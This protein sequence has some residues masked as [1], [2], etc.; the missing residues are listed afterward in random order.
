MLRAPIRVFASIAA[1]LVIADSAVAVT[2]AVPAVV[3]VVV[4]A[5]V[6]ASLA[7]L[8]TNVTQAGGWIQLVMPTARLPASTS[9]G[10]PAGRTG[11]VAASAGN[12]PASADGTLSGAFATSLSAP[13]PSGNGF[14]VTVA[15]N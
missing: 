6:M 13:T 11:R 2:A 14:R 10:N 1:L 12:R 8:I 3:T 4:P 9:A 7:D 15:F 5:S